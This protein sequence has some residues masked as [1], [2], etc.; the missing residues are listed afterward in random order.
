MTL[1]PNKF[2]P[3]TDLGSFDS[4]P[5]LNGKSVLEVKENRFSVLDLVSSVLENNEFSVDFEVANDPAAENE[6]NIDVV[7]VEFEDIS[8]KLVDLV[9]SVL[10]E[11]VD[12]LPKMGLEPKI[13]ELCVVFSNMLVEDLSP[14]RKVG[15]NNWDVL[16]EDVTKES[17]D[18]EILAGVESCSLTLSFSWNIIHDS[19]EYI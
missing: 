1:L 2:G 14:N 16:F 13:G 12:M 15:L 7:G 4:S 6:P 3:N 8:N 18:S 17:I 9:S 19:I 10:V 11:S 5:N